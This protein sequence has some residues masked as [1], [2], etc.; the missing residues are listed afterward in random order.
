MNI[1]K[2]LEEIFGSV[3]TREVQIEAHQTS[4]APDFAGI[5]STRAMSYIEL[6]VFFSVMS[7]AHKGAVYVVESFDDLTTKL[8]AST[9]GD[10]FPVAD[11]AMSLMSV[12]Y[13]QVY[14][15]ERASFIENAFGGAPYVVIL[16]PEVC[17]SVST[18]SRVGFLEL[19]DPHEFVGITKAEFMEIR[20]KTSDRFN[21]MTKAAKE[22][23]EALAKKLRSKLTTELATESTENT[24]DPD[25]AAQP[26]ETSA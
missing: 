15:T 5:A 12:G 14:S 6:L 17:T 2:A 1:D 4:I 21:A 9:G 13:I 19:A 3:T 10:E 16:N 22:R 7:G 11:A 8:Q 18:A 25:L 24:F 20:S 23:N 26:A